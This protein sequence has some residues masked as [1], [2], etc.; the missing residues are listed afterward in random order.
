MKASSDNDTWEMVQLSEGKKVV[1]SKWVFP[2]KYEPNRTVNRYKT[3]LVAQGFTQT[4]RID[5]EETFATIAKFNTIRVL[6]SNAANL[7][8]RL[9]QLDVKKAFL[10]GTL[11]EEV[12]MRYPLGFKIEGE[13]NK[14]CKLK[15]SLY[16]LKQ[17]PRAWLIR[18]GIVMKSLGYR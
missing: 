6:L 4:Y 12:Y 5:H 18:F 7:N 8:W 1:G 9:H 11:K 13:I 10:N 15:K 16:G 3:R 2:V 14:I 17:S